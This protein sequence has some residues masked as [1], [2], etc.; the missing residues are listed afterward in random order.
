MCWLGVKS[1]QLYKG[2]TLEAHRQ[3]K[4]LEENREPEGHGIL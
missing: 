1:H 3:G 2:Q 4:K